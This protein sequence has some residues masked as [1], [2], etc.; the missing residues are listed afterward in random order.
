M[1]ITL[2]FLLQ[3]RPGPGF[4]A[5][6]G[7]VMRLSA[8]REHRQ[9]G[10]G[11]AEPTGSW[12]KGCGGCPQPGCAIQPDVAS[13][14]YRVCAADTAKATSPSPVPRMKLLFTHQRDSCVPT[15]AGP[16]VPTLGP[17]RSTSDAQHHTRDQPV[18]NGNTRT[19]TRPLRL[20]QLL[21]PA[22]HTVF[23]SPRGRGRRRRWDLRMGFSMVP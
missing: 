6:E 10:G 20:R 12:D 1:K 23:K 15:G 16:H 17:P 22:C 9:G 14:S 3:I 7:W 5:Q 19:A 2:G 13:R 21:E 18:N 8:R 11:A 4:S